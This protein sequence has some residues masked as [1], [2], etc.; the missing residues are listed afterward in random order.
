MQPINK[1]YFIRVG[2]TKLS[3]YFLIFTATV[4]MYC[5][6]I[7]NDADQAPI[8]AIETEEDGNGLIK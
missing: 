5:K 7:S 6:F 3:H 4:Y 8:C 1:K 2:L